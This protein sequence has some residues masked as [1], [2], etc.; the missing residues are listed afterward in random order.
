MH[1]YN[2]LLL[3]SHTRYLFLLLYF[4]S[5][6]IVL[7]LSRSF[8]SWTEIAVGERKY[9][10]LL[11]AHETPSLF[12]YNINTWT[13]QPNTPKLLYQ[14]IS[15]KPLTFD[16]RFFSRLL[17]IDTCLAYLRT[18]TSFEY[19]LLKRYWLVRGSIDIEIRC[20]LCAL[21]WIC[22]LNTSL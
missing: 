20:V 7:I 13:M 18:K 15:K 14:P 8:L 12:H 9:P 11:F 21:V 19:K 10:K 16:F 2:G 6:E 22:S 4:F 1:H 5:L 3:S 17:Q